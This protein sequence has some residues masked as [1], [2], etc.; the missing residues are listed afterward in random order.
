LEYGFRHLDINMVVGATA[1]NNERAAKL[2]RWLGA[3]PVTLRQGPTWMT[4]RGWH[5]VDWA[6]TLHDWDKFIRRT[7]RRGRSGA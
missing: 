4:Q 5:E 3:K 2:A 6:L 1:S 7:A